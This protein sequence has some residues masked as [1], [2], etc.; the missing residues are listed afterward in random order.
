MGR[1]NKNKFKRGLALKTPQQARNMVELNG[2]YFPLGCGMHC[3]IKAALDS[4]INQ[5]RAALVGTSRARYGTYHVSEISIPSKPNRSQKGSRSRRG[6]APVGDDSALQMP[7][8]FWEI[9]AREQTRKQIESEDNGGKNILTKTKKSSSYS[10][11]I[12]SRYSPSAN[13]AAHAVLGAYPRT[14]YS[15]G[16]RL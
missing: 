7:Q 16:V 8:H 11:T 13:A 2:Y 15:A 5:L 12:D 4:Y 3:S 1:V 6:K 14:V 9:D 10:T